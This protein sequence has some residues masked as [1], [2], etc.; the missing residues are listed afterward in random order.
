MS[1]AAG[2]GTLVTAIGLMSGTSMDGIDAAIVHTDGESRVR[3]GAALT[4]PYPLA[5]RAKLGRVVAN[6]GSNRRETDAVARELTLAHAETVLRLLA[7]TGLKPE[8]VDVVGFHGQTV[9]HDPANR[10]TIQIGDPR[11]LAEKTGIPVVGQFR[12]ADVQA[13]GQGAP[14]APLYH[15]ARAAE[16]E[17]PVAV[18]NIGGVANVTWLGAD[19]AVLAFDTGPGNALIDDF[20]H[21]RTGQPYDLSGALSLSGKVDQPIL[22]ALLQNAYFDRPA[23]KSLDRNAFDAGAVTGLSTQ[24]GAATLASF[25]VQAAARSI[26]GIGTPRS[27]LVC[28]GGR[29]NKALMAGL[30]AALPGVD[31]AP[32]ESVGWRGDALEAEAFGYLAVRS[33]RGLPLSLPTTTGVPHP[34]TG[35]QLFPAPGRTA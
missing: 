27:V 15:A 28:G 33:L 21:A 19:G 23:P 32:V 1:A 9:F 13:G 35:G 4:V 12:L 25:T 8:A 29:L 20:V 2:G 18:L 24:D 30:A 22:D 17:K 10:V 34:L 6:H 3:T 5:F 16:L 14:L 7:A 31:V 11:L 26:L